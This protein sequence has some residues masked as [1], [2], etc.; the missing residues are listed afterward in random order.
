MLASEPGAIETAARIARGESGALLECEAAIA[1]IEARDPPINAVVI[2]DFDRAREA[3]AQADALLAAGE[4]RPL[5]GVP[6]TVKE[7]FDVAGLPTSWGFEAHR[8]HLPKRDA[9]VVARLKA[10]GAVILGKTNVPVGLADWQAVNPIHGRTN[11]PHDLTRTCGGSSGGSAA[12]LASGMVPLEY[13][14]DIGGSIRVPAHFC[15]VWGHKP[16]YGVVPVEGHAPPGTDGARPALGV[17]G[18][19]A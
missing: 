1:R 7:S 13:G 5:L 10:A 19:M 18:P 4:R 3:A 16:S 14:S 12:A 9:I 2:R 8:E 17:A 11:N 6:M 15:G